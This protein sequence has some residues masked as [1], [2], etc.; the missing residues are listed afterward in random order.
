VLTETLVLAHPMIPFVTEEI[1]SHLP[2]SEGLLAAR[3]ES[4][5]AAVDE[6]AEAS[7]TRVIEAV[8]A[9][10]GWRDLTGVKVGTRVPARLVAT[11]YEETAEHIAALAKLTLSEDGATAVASIPV[12]GGAVEI[13]PTADVDPAAAER[14]RA[15]ERDRLNHEIARA[16][17]KLANEGFVNKAPAHVVQ[18]ERDKLEG[19]RAELD[20]LRGAGDPA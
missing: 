11:G 12:P 18:A 5:P 4:D 17:A 1:Y 10:R 15:V 3:G 2:D 9:L 14:K 13:L 7:L 6:A 20:A 19:L 8:Q 16:E